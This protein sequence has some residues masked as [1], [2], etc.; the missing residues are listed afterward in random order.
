MPYKYIKKQT[1]LGLGRAFTPGQQVLTNVFSD[2]MI[3]E[4]LKQGI[5]V[6]MGE[7]QPEAVK[8][9]EISEPLEGLAVKDLNKLLDDYGLPKVGNKATKIE[10]LQEVK[11][12]HS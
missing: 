8:V 11:D 1:H 5:I 4:M 6:K 9:V 7:R 10:K 3:N 2:H 12:A